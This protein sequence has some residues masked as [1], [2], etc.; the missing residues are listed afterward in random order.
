M[1]GKRDRD[2]SRGV[3]LLQLFAG[4]DL[5]I[6]RNQ[7]IDRRAAIAFDEGRLGLPDQRVVPIGGAGTM[8]RLSRYLAIRAFRANVGGS[9][10]SR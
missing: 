4:V 10:L 1:R 2:C 8:A 6:G 7:G 3:S 5:D 9:R